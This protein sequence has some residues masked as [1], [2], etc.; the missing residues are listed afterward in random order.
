MDNTNFLP[1]QPPNTPI[2]ESA[3]PSSPGESPSGDPQQQQQQ[4]QLVFL[5]RG[6]RLP[7]EID[8]IGLREAS[9]V[10]ANLLR[11]YANEMQGISAASS[12][13]ASARP[14]LPR[15]I[16]LPAD[17]NAFAIKAILHCLAFPG[18]FIRPAPGPTAREFLF[19]AIEIARYELKGNLFVPWRAWFAA[20]VERART[21]QELV[22]LVAAAWALGQQ[23]RFLELGL[24]L[25]V[26]HQGRTAA[27]FARLWVDDEVV[28]RVLPEGFRSIVGERAAQ[29]KMKVLD[30]VRHRADDDGCGCGERAELTSDWVD[31]W[32]E[33]GWGSTV[34]L[35]DLLRAVEPLA[36]REATIVADECECMEERVL[37]PGVVR[38]RLAEAKRQAMICFVCV[39][40]AGDHAH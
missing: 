25:M 18:Q 21:A 38:E 36:E 26:Q 5:V 31:V 23:R 35:S 27:P 17:T 13:I 20:V 4:Q 30:L 34:P 1:S 37:G 7:V 12:P 9:P 19:L 22:W 39:E 33:H 29:L 15:E 6:E 14:A 24:D 40:R 28:K 10:F 3:S 2:E 16:A 11:P 8:L 32:D